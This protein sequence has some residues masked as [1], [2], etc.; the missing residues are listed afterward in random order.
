MENSCG[1]HNSKHETTYEMTTLSI[2]S[3]KEIEEEQQ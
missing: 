2:I 1:R 3:D